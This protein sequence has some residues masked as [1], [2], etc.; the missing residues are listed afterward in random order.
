MAAFDAVSSDPLY[1]SKVQQFDLAAVVQ[2]FDQARAADPGV[3]RWSMMNA[4]LDAHLASSDIAALGGDLAYRYGLMGD[5]SAIG[6]AAAQ[7][8]VR[9]PQFGAQAQTLR[10]PADLKQGPTLLP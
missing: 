6:L 9:S 5:L 10:P 7:D 4:L 2:R 1:R 8:V 3:D